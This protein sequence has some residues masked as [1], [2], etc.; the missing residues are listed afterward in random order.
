M[1]KVSSFLLL[2]CAAF[3][4]RAEAVSAQEF[5]N[6]TAPV[7]SQITSVQA[8]DN[9]TCRDYST[10][11]TLG[12]RQTPIVGRACQQPDGSWRIV[13]RGPENVAPY[14]VTY[15]PTPGLYEEYDSSPLWAFPIGFSIGLPFFIDRSNHFHRFNDF[16]H[17]RRVSGFEHRGGFGGSHD[18]GGFHEGGGHR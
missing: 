4:M 17:F 12:G 14:V 2:T 5:V 13:E 15:Q 7:L 18:R 1:L 9:G 10:V 6:T 16:G 8:P 3:L 11:A